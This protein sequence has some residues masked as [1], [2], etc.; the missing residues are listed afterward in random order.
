MY[1]DQC[2]NTASLLTRSQC[3]LS[4]QSMQWEQ[5]NAIIRL[6]IVFY[7]DHVISNASKL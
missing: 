1:G 3:K 2:E 6:E 7:Y 5:F 4:N